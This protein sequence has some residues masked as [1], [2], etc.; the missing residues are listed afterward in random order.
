[1][2]HANGWHFDNG[3]A[4]YLD[5]EPVMTP[6]E[7]QSYRMMWIAVYGHH[8]SCEALKCPLKRYQPPGTQPSISRF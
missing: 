6:G 8:D 7:Y 4:S 3:P 1:M 2:V 5:Q